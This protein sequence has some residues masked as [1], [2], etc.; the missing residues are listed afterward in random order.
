MFH[1]DCDYA[2]CEV[3]WL[4]TRHIYL[5]IKKMRYFGHIT[6]DRFFGNV[7]NLYAQCRNFVYTKATTKV[8]RPHILYRYQETKDQTKN[9]NE[10]VIVENQ[11][12]RKATEMVEECP[13]STEKIISIDC[14]NN[15]SVTEVINT[16]QDQNS[17][18]L[19]TTSTVLEEVPPTENLPENGIY[20]E[21]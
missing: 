9:V 20:K 18:H 7:D 3:Y 6:N 8:K 5:E 21:A 14:D 4:F 17:N 10:I 16:A 13:S 12:I 15:E 11:C 19:E 2:Q 1:V